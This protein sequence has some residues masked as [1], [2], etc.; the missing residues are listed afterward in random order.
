MSQTPPH[1]SPT[2]SSDR[3][4]EALGAPALVELN[5]YIALANL[6]A[7]MNVAL[8]RAARTAWPRRAISHRSPSAERQRLTLAGMNDDPFVTHRSLL[9]PVAYEIASAQPRTPRTSCRR[10]GC[11]GMG[12]A[13]TPA[14]RCATP[15]RTWSGRSPARP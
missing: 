12:S 3:L 2:S 11:G 13:T 5:A 8:E 1:G 6:Y 9:F 15:A 10:P 4:L 14:T 7:R